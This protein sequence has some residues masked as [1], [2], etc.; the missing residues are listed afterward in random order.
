MAGEL[1]KISIKTPLKGLVTCSLEAF[2]LRLKKGQ[3]HRQVGAEA[4]GLLN[5]FGER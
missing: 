4:T 5:F 2:F 3:T 1:K